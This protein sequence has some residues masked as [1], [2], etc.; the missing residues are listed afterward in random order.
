[1]YRILYLFLVLFLVSCSTKTLESAPQEKQV[2]SKQQAIKIAK[3]LFYSTDRYD[4]EYEY[5]F[6]IKDGYT[7]WLVYIEAYKEKQFILD[8]FRG[9]IEVDKITGNTHYIWGDG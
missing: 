3:E 6:T 7:I 4:A 8:A 9:V 1:M 2:I 5:K